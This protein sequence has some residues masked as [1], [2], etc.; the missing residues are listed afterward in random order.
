MLWA[1][2]LPNAPSAAITN[3]K[4]ALATLAPFS[5]SSHASDRCAGVS[6][7]FWNNAKINNDSNK[8]AGGLPLTGYS[9]TKK[10]VG[11]ASRGADVPRCTRG[12][13]ISPRDA[14]GAFQDDAFDP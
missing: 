4:V 12:D 6:N 7:L 13:G 3:N 14:S 11:H 9:P 10:K 8:R 5:P 2:P 1:P